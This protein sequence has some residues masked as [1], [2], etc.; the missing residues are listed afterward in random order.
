M[1]VV[2]APDSFKGSLGAAGAAR[3]LAEGWR[4]VRPQDEL[5][6][7]PMADGGEGT[8]AAV[9]TAHPDS[10]RHLVPGCTGPDGR[11]VNG[12]Y[13]LL[14]DGTAVVE[15]AVASGL[16]LLERPA[17]LT[18]GTRGTGETIAA[19]LDR[20]RPR[21]LL[22]ALGGSAGTDGGAGLLSALGLRLTDA[23]GHQPPGG[24]AALGA[25]RHADR[26][27]LRPPPPDG[28]VLLTDVTNPLLGPDGAAAVYGPQK[29]ATPA[30]I[31]ILEAG[32]ARLAEVLGGEPQL[33]G[34]GAAGG[35][36]YGL[37]AGWGARIAPG[38]AAVAD[39]L[40]L[41]R[42]LAGADLVITGEGRYDLTSLRGKAVGE[43]A[44]RATAARVPAVVIAGAV[45]VGTPR[46]GLHALRSLTAL[47]GTPAEA[48]RHP[49]R[50]LRTAAARTARTFPH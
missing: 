5:L 28:V 33:P 1:R 46:A 2:L 44:R 50:W 12:R 19:A 15:L 11:P 17:P 35:T 27:A 47:A 10:T 4:T 25:V 16:P 32:L 29:G 14:P 40:G 42:A 6:L 48:R 7:C 37:H 3:A 34:S 43:V 45:Q 13:A 22:L 9:T 21:R 18:A 49:T 39:L 26:A 31:R 36:A 24:G 8:L 38:A 20:H 23:D 41:D 30:D